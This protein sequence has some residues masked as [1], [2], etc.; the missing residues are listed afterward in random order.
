MTA[1]LVCSVA[2]TPTVAWWFPAAGLLF[3]AVGTGLALLGRGPARFFGVAIGSFAVL[4]T[5][6]T[7]SSM[8]T[9]HR[10][11]LQALASPQTPVVEGPVTNFHP[12]PF[13]GHND[14]SFSV[15]GVPFFYSEYRI[16]GAFNQPASHGGPI[17]EGLNVRIH[18]LKGPAYDGNLIIQ[19]DTCRG[20]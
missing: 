20:R 12:E 3:L 8:W 4:W 17:H 19:L 5:L 10:D 2:Y 14:E 6:T 13:G 15:A 9:R 7:A 1:Q 18:Y 11:L 16:T